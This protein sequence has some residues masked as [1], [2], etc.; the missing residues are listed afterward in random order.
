M[1]TLIQLVIVC[2]SS[3]CITVDQGD[4]LLFP[5]KQTMFFKQKKQTFS[6]KKSRQKA[7][8]FT[9]KFL[10]YLQQLYS[11][12][13]YESNYLKVVKNQYSLKYNFLIFI[14][15]SLNT[16]STPSGNMVSKTWDKR[17][18][19]TSSDF[20][21]YSLERVTHQFKSVNLKPSIQTCQ[22]K[23]VNSNSSMHLHSVQI[24]FELFYHHF[25]A[26]LGLFWNFLGLLWD[27]FRIIQ[28]I[29]CNHYR[30]TW[31][32]FVDILG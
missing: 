20:C 30:I 10:V 32:L 9:H 26:L 19:A 1:F 23:P 8:I 28:G 3:I 13:F 4:H 25:E 27:F 21:R 14:L 11:Q 15:L 6:S 24:I 5:K 12:L 7:N 16:S 18:K 31:D 22:F 29:L 2:S 17:M